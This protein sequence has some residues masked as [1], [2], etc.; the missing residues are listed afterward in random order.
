MQA[1]S[2]SAFKVWA[3]PVPDAAAAAA[4]D[5]PPRARA[6]ASKGGARKGLTERHINKAKSQVSLVAFE[7]SFSLSLSL[8]LSLTPFCHSLAQWL[9][10][11]SLMSSRLNASRRP[12]LDMLS[13]FGCVH[14]TLHFSALLEFI[15]VFD[16]LI[17]PTS[18]SSAS[19]TFGYLCVCV[20][21]QAHA[22]KPAQKRPAAKRR[23][24]ASTVAHVADTADAASA[25]PG[26]KD[27]SNRSFSTLYSV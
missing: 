19:M 18:G 1:A 22:K 26:E 24:S 17:E 5:G 15:F 3:D 16:I 11:S 7:L 27:C 20:C 13:S 23:S 14:D 12:G 2:A 8:S 6:A 25:E 10:V 21:V 4:A 9:A